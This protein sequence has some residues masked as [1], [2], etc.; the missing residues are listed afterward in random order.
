MLLSD[1]VRC[2]FGL[3]LSYVYYL[4]VKVSRM[5][6]VD[7]WCEDRK[8]PGKVFADFYPETP[9]NPT[10]RI[11]TRDIHLLETS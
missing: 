1:E 7:G 6:V 8:G 5:K 9:I 11:G 2:S 4:T 3:I 10:F